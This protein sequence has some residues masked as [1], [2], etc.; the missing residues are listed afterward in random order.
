MKTLR[1][2]QQMIT[3][4][5]DW[6]K[7][8]RQGVSYLLKGCFIRLFHSSRLNN[9]QKTPFELLN[10]NSRQ[11][12]YLIFEKTLKPVAIVLLAEDC[13]YNIIGMGDFFH[14]RCD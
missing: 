3:S 6:E 13:N 7:P 12:S 2:I 10:T 4:I 14:L 8:L 11:V 1:Q 5:N 9:A